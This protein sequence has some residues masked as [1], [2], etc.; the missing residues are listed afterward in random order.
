MVALAR[1][2]IVKTDIDYVMRILICDINPSNH[3]VRCMGVPYWVI[4]LC[5]KNE[6]L[7]RYRFLPSIGVD[8]GW[9]AGCAFVMLTTRS[10]LSKDN[11]LFQETYPFLSQTHPH[12][13][14]ASRH[15]RPPSQFQCH[16]LSSH[17][18]SH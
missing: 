8:P 6:S 5:T 1:R 10:P 3:I 12:P 11:K 2:E 9:K 14:L 7:P 18:H 15:V 4:C 13:Q 17:L 16:R